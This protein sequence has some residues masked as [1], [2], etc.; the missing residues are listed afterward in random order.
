MT[1]TEG[2]FTYLKSMLKRLFLSGIVISGSVICAVLA[3]G[4]IDGVR[5]GDPEYYLFIG[6]F[7]AG[8]VATFALFLLI[9]LRK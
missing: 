5:L 3:R 8:A 7:L 9:A 1:G 6:A 4:F 2:S